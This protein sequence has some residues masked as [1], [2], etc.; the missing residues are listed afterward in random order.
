MNVQFVVDSTS[1]FVLIRHVCFDLLPGLEQLF[2]IKGPNISGRVQSGRTLS[3]VW[4]TGQVIDNIHLT[5]YMINA[6]ELKLQSR[7]CSVIC[8]GF[9]WNFQALSFGSR[10]PYLSNKCQ[11]TE[12]TCYP[13][14]TSVTMLGRLYALNMFNLNSVLPHFWVI[15]HGTSLQSLAFLIIRTSP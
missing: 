1:F 10:K 9:T 2:W 6:V 5:T 12:T 14:I 3:S 8:I 11:R 15:G 13:S 7:S 4:T